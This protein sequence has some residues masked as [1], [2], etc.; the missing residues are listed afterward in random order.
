M[1]RAISRD[2]SVRNEIGKSL[3]MTA[4]EKKISFLNNYFMFRKARNVNAEK[5][6][7]SYLNANEIETAQKIEN[8]E[9]AEKIVTEVV[10]ETK[11]KAR[12]IGRKIKLV[13][14]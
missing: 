7:A 10:A 9:E 1:E 12:R 14:K 8:E 5:I 11:P 2:P 3:T 6:E 13:Q 4:G